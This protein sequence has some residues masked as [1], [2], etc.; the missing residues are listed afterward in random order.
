M[1]TRAGGDRSRARRGAPLLLVHGLGATHRVWDPVIDL[2]A[3]HYDV[4]AV[5]L[6]GHLD[7]PPIL[8]GST[9]TLASLIDALCAE[10]DREGID[11]AHVVGNSLGGLLALELARRG[12]A[13][14]VVALA[15]IGC[16]TP[17][18]IGPLVRRL[19]VSQIAAGLVAPAGR[20]LVSGRLGRRLLFADAIHRPEALRPD[21]AYQSLLAYAGCQGFRAILAGLAAQ[22]PAQWPEPLAC[23]VCVAWPTHDRLTPMHPFADRFAAAL[24]TATHLTIPDAGH[25]PMFDAPAAVAAIVRTHARTA[26]A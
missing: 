4:L 26:P 17:R 13:L 11:K 21:Q 16:L 9:V 15:P 1:D 22:P 10:L 2:L 6:P 5:T 8:S 18:E 14:S 19:R 7:G 12:R 25:L 23:P 3:P 24:P 20:L